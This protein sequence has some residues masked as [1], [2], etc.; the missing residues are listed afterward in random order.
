[1]V[2]ALKPHL[3][4]PV[5]LNLVPYQE[6]PAVPFLVPLPL[7]ASVVLSQNYLLEPLPEALPFPL[8]LDPLVLQAQG[9]H[10]LP[11]EA[12]QAVQVSRPG[13]W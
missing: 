7:V 5:V 1:M 3:K 12:L 10:P 9:C 4:V 11:Q 6:A 2:S 8:A 13:L